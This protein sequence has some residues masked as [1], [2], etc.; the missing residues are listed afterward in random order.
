[1][2]QRFLPIPVLRFFAS[3]IEKGACVRG[4]KVPNVATQPR[5]FFDKANQWAQRQGQAGLGY[6]VYKDGEG[7]GPIAKNLDETRIKNLL[8]L[9]EMQEGDAIFFIC[10]PPNKVAHFA[11]EARTYLAETLKLIADDVF[12]FCWIVDFPMFERDETSGKI[13]FSHNPFSMPQGG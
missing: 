12:E 7:Q 5:S 10:L 8:K 2:L 9:A 13:I 4:V 3:Q 1:M 6:L 11:G